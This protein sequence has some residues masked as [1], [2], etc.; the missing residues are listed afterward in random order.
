MKF[1]LHV[2]YNLL[3][4]RELEDMWVADFDDNGIVEKIS[5]HGVKIS[6]EL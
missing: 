5:S 6:M 1:W 4:T 2:K 3:L